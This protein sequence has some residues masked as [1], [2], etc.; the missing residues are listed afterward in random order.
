MDLSTADR[1][2]AER[3]FSAALRCAGPRDECVERS[4]IGTLRHGSSRP[5]LAPE[6]V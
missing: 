5:L 3:R 6:R 1:R 2:P 4:A